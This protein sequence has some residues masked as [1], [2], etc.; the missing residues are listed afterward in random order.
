NAQMIQAVLEGRG[1]EAHREAIAAA[2]GALLYLMGDA[3]T[4]R[5]GVE[6]AMEQLLSGRVAEHVERLKAPVQ[7]GAGA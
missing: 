1:A 3:G 5:S 7:A 6:Q 2:T 4:I